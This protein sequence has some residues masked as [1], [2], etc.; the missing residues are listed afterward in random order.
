MIKKFASRLKKF[1]LILLAAAVLLII[2]GL[3]TLQSTVIA[4]Q[5]LTQT[6]IERQ[7]SV[8]VIGFLF[9]LLLHSFDY[10][11]LRFLAPGLY[12]LSLLILL[13]VLFFAPEV[14]GVKRW[15]FLGDLQL[16]P[17][18]LTKLLVIVFAA[19][20]LAWAK[21][22]INSVRYL[23]LYLLLLGL[24]L[25]LIVLEP[26][27]GTALVI[28][29]VGLLL[30]ITAPTKI[31]WLLPLTLL[32]LVGVPSGWVFLKAYQRQRIMAFLNPSA[33][34]LG[35]GYNLIQA[36]I[37]IG[38]GQLTGRGWGRGTQSHLQFLPEQHTDFIFATF[39]EEMGFVGAV[40]VL[41]LFAI[42]IWRGFIIAK[43]APDLF[44][45]LLALGITG[46]ILVQAAINIG[47]NLGLAPI[48]GIP[49]PFLSYGGSSLLTT[50]LGIGV[51][52]SIAAQTRV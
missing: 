20:F 43:N 15:F 36:M 7:A 11:Y 35:A 5:G 51:L 37:A 8:A 34:P 16:Q 4:G 1:D 44:G 33:D 31:R 24:P 21:E 38:S 19:S 39:S 42:I 48:T 27:L 47:M 45:S 17:S 40:L 14:R 2:I 25:G 49:L 28:A 26:D 46:L 22:N 6:L 18:E 30:L 9:I 52:E 3:S 10:R 29:L 13:L 32:M 41:V 23:S 50:I 12:I